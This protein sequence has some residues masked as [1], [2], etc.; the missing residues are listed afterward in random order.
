MRRLLY[1]SRHSR[2]MSDAFSQSGIFYYLL[3]A[4]APFSQ[5]VRLCLFSLLL[6]FITLRTKRGW[7]WCKV[8]VNGCIDST[9]GLEVVLSTITRPL[10]LGKCD[11]LWGKARLVTLFLRLFAALQKLHSFIEEQQAGKSLTFNFTFFL[12]RGEK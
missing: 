6:S 11:S 9:D 8:N 12:F 1:S 7:C 3:H 5:L 10:H 2:K 4:Y